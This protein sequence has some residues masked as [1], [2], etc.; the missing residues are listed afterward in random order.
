MKIGSIS[1]Q[2]PTEADGFL[3]AA[4]EA[5]KGVAALHKAEPVPLM[6]LALLCGHSCETALKA[7]LAKSGRTADELRQAPFG[8][9]LLKLWESAASI[10]PTLGSAL[11]SWLVRL[12]QIYN[13]PFHLRYPLGIHGMQYPATEDMF[14]G[15]SHI[16]IVAAESIRR[17]S[18]A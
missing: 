4:E 8:H 9:N 17:P 2:A 18:D 5:F 13:R 3:V 12:N 14:N 15:T 7:L 11:P 10:E 16:V 1:L 6:G